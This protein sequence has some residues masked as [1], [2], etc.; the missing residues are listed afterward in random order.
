MRPGTHDDI[1]RMEDNSENVRIHP[2]TLPAAY[3]T[4]GRIVYSSN[5]AKAA[6]QGIVRIQAQTMLRA[7]PQRTAEVRLMDPTPTMAPVMV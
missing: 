6:E 4:N 3:R 1:H 2:L 5:A 7:I